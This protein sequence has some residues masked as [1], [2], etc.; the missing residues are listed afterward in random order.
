MEWRNESLQ[1]ERKLKFK[2]R[3]TDSLCNSRLQVEIADAI[4]IIPF[5]SRQRIAEAFFSTTFENERKKINK[6]NE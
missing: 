3:G 5:S 1:Y 2:W 6:W 4:S